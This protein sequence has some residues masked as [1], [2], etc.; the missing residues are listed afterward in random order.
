MKILKKT[1]VL[2][3]TGKTGRRVAERLARR[4]LPV[5]IGSRRSIVPFDWEDRGT[6]Q[7]AL[8]GVGAVY[9]TYYP[10][11]A[12]P[13]AAETVGDFARLAVESGAE[14]L[15]LL[16]GRGE[17]GARRGEEV[18]KAAGADWT[19]LRAAWFNQN[20]SENFFVDGIRC[21]T[22]A[23]PVGEVTEPF[24]DAEDIAEAAVA[25]LSE[26]GHAGQLYE[27]TGPRLMTFPQA[28]AEVA[29]ASGRDIRFRS[30][31]A[32]DFAA[33]MAAEGLPPDFIDLV[34]ELFTEVLD[35]RNSR[36]ADGVER[37]LGRPPRDF[38][39]YA[40]KAAASGIWRPREDEKVVSLI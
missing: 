31:P 27:L 30:I 10:D 32:A 26:A 7:G 1:L 21:G 3:G 6:W 16:S 39:D 19:I 38:A 5:R 25:A 8:A 22:L 34:M 9:I 23:L 36:L 14:R 13:G 33:G 29:E 24:L 15:V 18:V 2:G 20:F 11:L 4:G 12:V 17:P 40:R 28:I 37:A 35:G